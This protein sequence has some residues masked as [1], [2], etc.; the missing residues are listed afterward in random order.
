MSQFD[1]HLVDL[2]AVQHEVYAD[3]VTVNSVPV[4]G[5]EDLDTYVFDGV[6]TEIRTLEIYTKDEPP[7]LAFNQVVVT[8]TGAYTIRNYTREDGTTTLYLQ[9]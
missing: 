4:E 6:N 5:I 2:D 1:E 9:D 7:G 3:S 8:G